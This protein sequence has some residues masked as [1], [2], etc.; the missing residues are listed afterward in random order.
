[1]TWQTLHPDRRTARVIAMSRQ[2]TP[3]LALPVAFAC[4]CACRDVD[5]RASV[6]SFA[7]TRLAAT[8]SAAMRLMR[9]GQTEAHQVLAE[10][11]ACVPS[12]IDDLASGPP[13]LQ[14]FT[15]LLDIAAM[16]QQYLHSRLF[17]S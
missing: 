8:I 6:E 16:S 9:I 10:A 5:Q 2:K 14:S 4:A 7:Y 15:P 3:G 11:L 12:A 13:V 1:T 17:R